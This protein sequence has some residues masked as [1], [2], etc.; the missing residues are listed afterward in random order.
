MWCKILW[1]FLKIK[2]FRVDKYIEKDYK[3]LRLSVIFY[4]VFENYIIFF[5]REKNFSI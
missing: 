2:L 4:I 3:R 5:L 1:F